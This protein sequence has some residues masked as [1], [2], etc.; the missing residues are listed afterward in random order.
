MTKGNM[1]WRQHDKRQHNN[2]PANERQTGGQ[3]PADKRRRGVGRPRLRAERR[4]RVERTRGESRGRE[5]EQPAG[6][7]EMAAVV[8]KAT[9]TATAMVTGNAVSPPSRDLATTILVLT[10]EAAAALI[11]DDA[12]GG[13]GGVA[14]LISLFV[15]C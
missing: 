13:K 10:A 1:R 5:A 6:E 7:L 14:N 9:A 12:D 4:R 8:A 3:A 11:A 2:Q 15:C